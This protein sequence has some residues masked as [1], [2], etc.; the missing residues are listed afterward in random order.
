MLIPVCDPL[1]VCTLKRILPMPRVFEQ[2]LLLL[3]PM[4][5]TAPVSCAKNH[6]IERRRA[7]VKLPRA[8]EKERE[9][10]RVCS[11][12]HI[13]FSRDVISEIH[14]RDTQVSYVTPELSDVPEKGWGKSIISSPVLEAT[15][16]GAAHPNQPAHAPKQN[17]LLIISLTG[18]GGGG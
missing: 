6:D 18:G 8:R 3:E 9:E 16:A 12:V 13:I 2:S 1:V 5:R 14:T 11:V 15:L 17:R 4:R 10:D 7:V